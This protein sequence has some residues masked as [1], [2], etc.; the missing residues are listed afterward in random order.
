MKHFRATNRLTGEI[1]FLCCDDAAAKPEGY[2]QEEWLLEPM[3]APATEADSVTGGMQGDAAAAEQWA[4]ERVEEGA[5]HATAAD[6]Q[7]HRRQLA[8]MALWTEIQR[9]KLVQATNNL[10]ATAEERARQFPI[11][12]ALVEATGIGLGLVAQSME[13]RLWPRV[14]RMARWEAKVL[15]G[16]DDI[17]AA[18]TA[19][20]KIAAA[21]NILWTE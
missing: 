7:R 17:R 8:I 5:D 4:R 13:T 21:L 16:H 10:P 15:K 20:A 1:Q 6:I 18:T 19:E 2:A 12:M 14:R 11:L 9:L 3:A